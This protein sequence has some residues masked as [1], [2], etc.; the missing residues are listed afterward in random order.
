M[1]INEKADLKALGESNYKWHGI[2]EFNYERGPDQAEWKK[3]FIKPTPKFWN[4]D[5]L[6]VDLGILMMCRY[7]FI[8]IS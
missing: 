2:G 5:P 7:Q 3:G 1:N 8:S 6:D 4:K